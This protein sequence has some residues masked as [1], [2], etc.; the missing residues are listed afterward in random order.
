MSV[1][2]RS[3]HP[4]ADA[5][6]SVSARFLR[7]KWVLR[8]LGL[9]AVLSVWQF[10]FAR[11]NPIFS[12]PP[13]NVVR[14]IPEILEDPEYLP[15]ILSTL[16]LFV[17]GFAIAAVLGIL[18]G[19]ALARFRLFDLA[20]TPYLNAL[21]A[22]PLPAIVPIL[23][24]IMGYRLATKIVI[25]VVL[26]IFPILINVQQGA[27]SVDVTML[28]VARSFRVREA[29]LWWDVILPS[30]LPYVVVGL[31]LGAAR[32]M[33]GTAV[34]ELYTSPDGLGYLILRYGF[35]FNMD[36]MLV[37]VLTFTLISIALSLT[38]GLLERRVQRW[39][40]TST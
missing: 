24:A 5:R 26:A 6:P 11:V 28:E 34:A 17:T 30:S 3:D 4:G 2:E 8:A 27:R 35:R 1:V 14:S 37:V 12:A 40:V 39:A 18:I 10:A 21:Y 15:A 31:R 9:V 33:I 23:T 32:G 25:V 19:L 29:R 13:T 22:S 16:R 38:I 20:F 7:N 36:A